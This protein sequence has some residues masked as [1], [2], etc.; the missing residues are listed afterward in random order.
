MQTPSKVTLLII[1]CTT[2]ILVN[3]VCYAQYIMI[4]ELNLIILDQTENNIE[5]VYY[6]TTGQMQLK[7]WQSCRK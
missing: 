3:L 6:S 4:H 7:R 5:N 1:E 2:V